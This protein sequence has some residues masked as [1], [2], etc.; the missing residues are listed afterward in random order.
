MTARA[1]WQDGLL[2][3]GGALLCLGMGWVIGGALEA[4]RGEQRN[5]Q[6]V[7]ANDSVMLAYAATIAGLEKDVARG[8]VEV[9]L[10][11][12]RAIKAEQSAVR[13]KKDVVRVTQALSASQTAADS[14]AAYPPLVDALT[15]TMV[16]QGEA[17]VGYRDA[18]A[19]SQQRSA[20]L[21][22]RI[23]ADSAALHQ[24]RVTIAKLITP[25]PEPSRPRLLGFLPRPTCVAGVG[26]VGGIRTGSGVGV[27]CGLPL[28]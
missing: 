18:L 12:E 1:W 22:A 16:E 25:R 8:T 10:A 5:Q 7:A 9:A 24:S 2:L 11:Q 15:A 6:L 26:V 20:A 27:L 13:A 3:L 4:R 21:Q 23:A 28:R 17:I 14:L 19:A